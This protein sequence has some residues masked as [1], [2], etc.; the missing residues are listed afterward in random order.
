LALWNWMFRAGLA[1]AVLGLAWTLWPAPG[2][3]AYQGGGRRGS[4]YHHGPRVA[5]DRGHWDDAPA[6]SRFLAL[7]ELLRWDGYRV[8]RSKQ[9]LVPEFLRD[10]D[11][12]VIG[13]AMPYPAALGRLAEATGLAGGATF[14]PDEVD[15]V[16][17]WV[18][19]GGSL[20]LEANVPGSG[21][22]SAALAAAL[23]LAI[24]DC[25]TPVFF[26]QAELGEHVILAGRPEENE[27]VSSAAVLASGW[28]EA[29]SAG[30]VQ[31]VPLLEA[32]PSAPGPCAAGKPL[33]VALEFGRGRVVALSAQLERS[34][35][36]I[37]RTGVDPRRAGN[38]Q[39][40]LNAMHWLSRAD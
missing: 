5:I 20:L 2:E 18:H 10:I 35:D 26:P 15:A 6:D 21:R 8:T 40:V 33:A 17:D 19:A 12:L 37:R 13:N 1:I 28:I 16:R 9:Y 14:A 38:R 36:I 30:A 22:A 25:P 32:P 11:V 7:G 23:G 3:R 29:T 39:F 34:D 31:V 27:H 24:H 4:A